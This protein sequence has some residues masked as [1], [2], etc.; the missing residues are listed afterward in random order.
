MKQKLFLTIVMLITFC[1]FC[2]A[3]D[4]EAYAVYTSG[5]RTLSFY[6]D[7]KRSER[8]GDKYD[9]NTGYNA[10]G[11]IEDGKKFKRVVFAES[12]A[13]FKPT[14]THR[15]FIYQTELTE[16]DKLDNL[17]TDNVTDMSYMFANCSGLTSLDLS[18]WN[19]SKVV[20][21]EYMFS[22]CGKLSNLDL[23]GWNTGKVKYTSCMFSDCGK[24][25]NL[26]LSGWNTENVTN[27]AYMFECCKGL[28]SLNV[29]SWNTGKVIY[30]NCMFAESSS[31]TSLDLSG[32]NTE[33][34][35]NMENMFS[36]CSGL[37]SLDLSGWN[38]GKVTEIGSLFYDCNNLE[39]IYAGDGW[40]IENASSS[41]DMFFNCTNLVG[42]S[43]TAFNSSH[44]DA[45]YARIDGGT[46]KP[47]YFTAKAYDLEIAGRKVKSSNM[48]DVLG[49]GIFS[50]SP[51]TKT[52]T[53]KGSY[54]VTDTGTIGSSQ[55]ICNNIE[56]LTI[57]VI[58]DAVLE[59]NGLLIWLKK[60]TT[61][62][63]EGKLTLKSKSDTGIYLTEGASAT[64]ENMNMKIEGYW[65]IAGPRNGN[66]GEKTTIKSSNIAIITSTAANQ[67]VASAI[68][69]LSGGIIL[70]DCSITYPA[71]ATIKN[72][73]VYSGYSSL[74]KDVTITAKAGIS[75]GVN[76]IENG[77]VK[78]ENST[79]LYNLQGQRVTNPVRGGIYIQNGKK[80]IVK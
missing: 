7:A 5:D 13:S 12:F 2:K 53:V 9:L 30:M 77:K 51:S 21:M 80:F 67:N 64:I 40:N 34:V 24:L 46:S 56:G 23:S 17:K 28:T 45:T 32:W 16:I 20:Y 59:C 14:S 71:N 22:D 42:G 75:T 57:D 3:A 52:L 39:T 74:A 65:G 63:G 73:G 6:Y 72:G 25:S 35:T 27:M 43:G 70:E 76:P 18:E 66:S 49:N 15:W 36:N 8:E 61:I 62:K 68:S 78:I 33:N 38:T 4:K 55:L 47:G 19:T 26:D 11:W 50:Y 54:T 44:T 58:Q 37:T 60:N 29:S 10:P 31:L 41:T 48:S 1:G 69:D 79:P